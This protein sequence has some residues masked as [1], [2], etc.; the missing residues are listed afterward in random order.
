M[1]P[2]APWAPIHFFMLHCVIRTQAPGAVP[3]LPTFPLPGYAMNDR[4]TASILQRAPV[5]LAVTAAS[6]GLQFPPA[7]RAAPLAKRGGKAHARVVGAAPTRRIK[8]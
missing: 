4:K 6:Y 3:I 5:I 7:P 8:A 1:V 2:T